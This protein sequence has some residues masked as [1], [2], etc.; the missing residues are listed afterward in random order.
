MVFSSLI[1]LYAFLPIVLLGNFLIK[2]IKFK[3]IF[4]MIAS[5]M[6]YSWGEPVWVILLL[7]SALVDYVI[8]N[9]IE[10]SRVATRR[11]KVNEKTGKILLLTSIAINLGFLIIFKYSGFFIEN[12]N[13][14]FHISLPIPQFNLPIG[15][16]FYTF[17]TMSYTIDV[18][19][20]QVKAEKNF[21]NFLMYVSF[22]PQLIAGPIVRY[23]DI[24]KQIHERKIALDYI[25][26]GITRFLIGLFKK[27]IIANYAGEMVNNSLGGNLNDISILGF[28]IGAMFYLFQLYFDFSGYSDMAIGLGKMFG[29]DFLENF[30]YPYTAK[31]IT[32]F[33]KRWHI[34]LGSF[35]K[36]Y[37]YIPLGGNKKFQIRNIFIVWLLTGFWH[38]ANW[39]YIFW[40]L[41]FFIVLLVEKLFLLKLL[42][43]LPG[44]S[45][46]FY[47]MFLIIVAWMIF[48]FEDLRKLGHA[49]SIMFGF[50]S[51][52]FFS[53]KDI[54]LLSNNYIF[55]IIAIIACTPI[56]KTIKALLHVYLKEINILTISFN[57]IFNFIVLLWCT[58]TIVGSTYNPFIYFRF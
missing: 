27:V 21:F 47:T 5:L 15:I 11:F 57:T 32:D 51:N 49:F 39:N 24:Q 54:I 3:N 25:S 2:P 26:K 52:L 46:H 48:Y 38:G 22:F 14:L 41:F 50:S 28:W 35:F 19:R 43:K 45:R 29:F 36:D 56:I 20:K 42:E 30:K 13:L 33:W 31:S 7:I 34:S 4:L 10:E 18:Y 53:N 8:S 23:I 1:F 9:A 40:G 12:L 44:F 6:F 16:S 58:A 37:V 55:I 17:Q